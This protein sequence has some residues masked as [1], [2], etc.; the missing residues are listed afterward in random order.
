LGHACHDWKIVSRAESTI[1]I[2]HVDPACALIYEVPGY[3]NGIVTIN[4]L[5]RRLALAEANDTAGSNIN[6]GKE[7]H[8]RGYGNHRVGDSA[9]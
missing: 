4:G 3:R 1:E 5:P 7:I 8:Y 6:G 2:H 9:S